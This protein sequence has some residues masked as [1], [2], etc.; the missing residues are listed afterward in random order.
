MHDKVHINKKWSYIT[1]VKQNYYSIHN[2]NFLQQSCKIKRYI[3]KAM[4]MAAVARPRRDTSQNQWCDRRL[5]IRR[6]F[7]KQAAQIRS[8]NREESTMETKVEV[9]VDK[10]QVENDH[11]KTFLSHSQQISTKADAI[12]SLCST[13]QCQTAYRFSPC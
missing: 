2:E 6:F 10:V 8:S 5:G 13:R 12:N 9:S 11:W 1:E 4:F 7:Y 3:T